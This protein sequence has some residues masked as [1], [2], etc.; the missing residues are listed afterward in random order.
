MQAE[1][2]EKIAARHLT[3]KENADV[4]PFYALNNRDDKKYT[5]YLL[6]AAFLAFFITYERVRVSDSNFSALTAL[7]VVREAQPKP[8][9]PTQITITAGLRQQSRPGAREFW[10]TA[11]SVEF[12]QLGPPVESLEKRDF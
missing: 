1:R 7:F 9:R 11:G 12:T 4:N 10:L 5:V 3:Q 6:T 2:H 8:R